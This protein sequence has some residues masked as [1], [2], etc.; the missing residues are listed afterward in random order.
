MSSALIHTFLSNTKLCVFKTLSFIGVTKCFI[1]I[2]ILFYLQIEECV[3]CSDKKASVLFKPCGHMCA[4]DGNDFYYWTCYFWSKSCFL[5][6]YKYV[7]LNQ[8]C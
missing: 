1:I 2:Y 3:V 6:N 8:K 7:V 5:Q 4:C